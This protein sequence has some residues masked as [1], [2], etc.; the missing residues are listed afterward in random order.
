MLHAIRD[1]RGDVPSVRVG[2]VVVDAVALRDRTVGVDR[3][4]VVVSGADTQLGLQQTSCNEHQRR[5]NDQLARASGDQQATFV[6]ERSNVDHSLLEGSLVQ[7]NVNRR[8]VG[9]GAASNRRVR[10]VEQGHA[11]ARLERGEARVQQRGCFDLLGV[12]HGASQRLG[13]AS[14]QGV[15]EVVLHGFLGDGEAHRHGLVVVT[16]SER[17]L[18]VVVGDRGAF[19]LDGGSPE[20]RQ[21][22]FLFERTLRGLGLVNLGVLVLVLAVLQTEEGIEP[23]QEF[24]KG[25]CA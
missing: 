19:R 17:F 23:R 24:F 4:D 18:R 1:V 7:V 11:V 8:A 13:V 12:R 14:R 22:H 3:V 25:L 9:V 5:R 20:A 21:L 6:L 10:G 2:Q 16:S 15:I